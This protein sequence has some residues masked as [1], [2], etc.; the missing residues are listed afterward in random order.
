MRLTNI[1][2]YVLIASLLASCSFIR[3]MK[4]EEKAGTPSCWQVTS[5]QIPIPAS[6]PLPNGNHPNL[7]PTPCNTGSNKQVWV[8]VHDNSD[9]WLLMPKTTRYI[10]NYSATNNY[11][12]AGA[13][14]LPALVANGSTSIPPSIVTTYYPC[15]GCTVRLPVHIANCSV[16]TN[17]G[18]SCLWL[19]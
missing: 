18:S 19:D 5:W 6:G 3:E 9:I 16:P 12:N 15:S 1:I 17:S 7:S 8:N 4:T 14:F 13:Y 10:A 2:F 11:P